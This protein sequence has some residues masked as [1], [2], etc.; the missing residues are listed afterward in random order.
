MVSADLLEEFTQNCKTVLYAELKKNSILCTSKEESKLVY[1]VESGLL[2]SVDE[3]PENNSSIN[4]I[5][6]TYSEGDLIV[7]ESNTYCENIISGDNTNLLCFS[8]SEYVA[9]K[10]LGVKS[11]QVKLKQ[12]LSGLS[13]LCR[14]VYIN[15]RSCI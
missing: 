14:L 1:M 12:F 5:R 9:L 2:Y 6:K 15:L 11:D 7:S 13:V 3:L 8:L 10:Q 4:K